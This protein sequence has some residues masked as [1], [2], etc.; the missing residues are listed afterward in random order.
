ML[1]THYSDILL[2]NWQSAVAK[3]ARRPVLG[4]AGLTRPPVDFGDP[5]ILAASAAANV[6]AEAADGRAV[7]LSD[8]PSRIAKAALDFAK[9]LVGGVKADA[10]AAQAEFARYGTKDPFWAECI[11]EFVEHYSLTK[12]SQAPY[13]EWTTLSDFVLPQSALPLSCKIAIIGDWGT[14]ELRAQRLLEEVA[15]AQPDILLHLGDIYYA[16]TSSEANTFYDNLMKAFP[17]KKPRILTLCGNHDMYSG[18]APYFALLNR[19]GQPASYFCLRN[20]YW[21]LLGAD[22]GRN[23]FDP[24]EG[25]GGAT[26]I[27]DYDEGETFSELAWH[28]DKLVNAGGRKTVLFTHH[29]LFTRNA[30]IA[31]K[32]LS[33]SKRAVNEL[34]LKQLGGFL[35]DIGLWIWGHEHNQLVYEP[36]AG[37]VRGRCIGASAIPVPAQTD[38]VT[39]DAALAGQAIPELTIGGNGEVKLALE[40]DGRFYQ[41]GYALLSLQGPKLTAEYFQFDAVGLR[42]SSMFIEEL[43]TFTMP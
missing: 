14:G 40:Q 18:A 34:L 6:H 9:S 24:L 42:S 2:S 1:P 37:L 8:E 20:Q 19:I 13:V 23:D 4:D 30:S 25:G 26:W 39:P 29:Q 32:G 22:T 11:A 43:D 10:V 12:H 5:R 15:K 38:L 31:H 17:A 33:P 28:K 7:N 21:Q 41:L 27:R 3:V 35:P 36:F 16:C